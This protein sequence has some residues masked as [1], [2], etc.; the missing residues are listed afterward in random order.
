MVNRMYAIYDVKAEFY[1]P[2]FVFKTEGLAIRVFLESAKDPESQISRYPADF[3]LFYLGTFDDSGAKI[4][5]TEA[6]LRLGSA[7]DFLASVK[8]PVVLK[9]VSK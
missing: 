7:Q 1:A 6:P 9:E 4:S 5:C 8:E 2:P 3:S